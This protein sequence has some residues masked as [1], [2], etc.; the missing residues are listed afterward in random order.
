MKPAEY[1][2]EDIEDAK[3][4]ERARIVAYLRGG[5]Q[6]LYEAGQDFA[7]DAFRFAADDLQSRPA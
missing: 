3:L 5:A 7:G 1:T 6:A 2:I 4:A